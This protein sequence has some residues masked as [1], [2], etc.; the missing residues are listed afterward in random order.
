MGRW[1]IRTLDSNQRIHTNILGFHFISGWRHFIR[2]TNVVESLIHQDFFDHLLAIQF[3]QSIIDN[4]LQSNRASTSLSNIRRHYM[5]RLCCTDAL[6]Q[7]FRRK[8]RKHHRVHRTDTSTSQHGHGRLWNHGHVNSDDIAFADTLRQQGIG[9]LTDF[10]QKFFV[11]NSTDIIGLIALPDDSHLISFRLRNMAINGIVTQ[12]QLASRKPTN[13]A[14]LKGTF[15]HTIK[16]SEPIELFFG[17]FA[18]EFF[19]I[20]N[21]GGMLRLI[22]LQ[23][24]RRFGP[25][26]RFDVGNVRRFRHDVHRISL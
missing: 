5:F 19:G 24:D 1:T 15:Q 6:R 14:M 9:N 2:R 20:L 10:S 7:G 21:T 13:I 23:T 26:N 17:L 22:V 16:L 4:I 8:S 11:G 12:V 18:P 25:N 3:G